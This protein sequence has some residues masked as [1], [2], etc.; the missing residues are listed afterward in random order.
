[1]DFMTVQQASEL[2][3]VS[4]R[5]VHKLCADGRIKGAVKISGVWLLPSDSQKPADARIKSGKYIIFRNKN[6]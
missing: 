2:W 6:E 1:M 4:P 5:R 3:E